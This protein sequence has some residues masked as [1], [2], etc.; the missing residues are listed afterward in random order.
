MN[1]SH[2]IAEIQR[3]AQDNDGRPLGRQ[4]FYKVT[5]IRESDWF[6]KYWGSWGEALTEADLSQTYRVKDIPTSS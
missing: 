3:T 2:I 4:R 1:K 5:G 6:G